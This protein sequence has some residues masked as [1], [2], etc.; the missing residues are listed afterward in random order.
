MIPGLKMLS[1]DEV[2]EIH[3]ASLQIL[4]KTG[5]VF[6]LD[7]ALAILGDHGAIIDRKKRLA[8]IPPHL[9]LDA[10][11]KCSPVVTLYGRDGQ[12]DLKAG[13]R[14][15]YFGTVGYGTF[16][17]D[18][19]T[20]QYRQA[21]YDDLVEMV[22]LADALENVDFILPPVCPQDQEP[23]LL[24]L[25]EFKGCLLHSRKPSIP[26]AYSRGHVKKMV[27]MAAACV[28]GYEALRERPIFSI[29]FVITS[30][31][32][33]RRDIAETIIECARLMVPIYM[34]AG[35]QGGGN[36][37]CTI[38]GTLALANAEALAGTV[39]AKLVNPAAP[40]IYASWA[41]HLDLRSANVAFGA[42]EFGLARVGAAQMAQFYRMPSGGGGL[43]GNS[44][45]LDVQQGWEKMAT[46][47]LPALAGLNMI[48]GQGLIAS[49]NTISLEQLVADD[50]MAAYVK[51]ILA[52]VTVD[53]DRLA[54]A[55]IE[56]QGPGGA[57]ISTP[58]TFKYH[59]QEY[60]SGKVTDR[61]QFNVHE[62]PEPKSLKTRI[63]RRLEERLAAYKPME[64]H[65]ALEKTMDEIIQG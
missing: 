6:E 44:K 19:R 33:I 26:E 25:Y 27:D 55:E 58:H 2:Q 45:L 40:I 36:A 35:P 22:R 56:R 37:P 28:G 50:E 42:P 48:L 8:R 11:A 14:R 16:T 5:A 49:E 7:E 30:P 63:R 43:I 54:V 53:E 31:L 18:W 39:L 65:L 57:F 23:K 15:V 32:I 13:G 12:P 38:A 17:L 61:S 62:S 52:G 59:R 60:W 21:L 34:G 1:D 46:A 20:G 24:D 51:R 29:I 64:D 41:R 10:V 4:E 9:V 47:L 3:A